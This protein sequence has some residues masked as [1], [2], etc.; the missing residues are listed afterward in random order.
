MIEVYIWTIIKITKDL[1]LNANADVL[2][3]VITVVL[4]ANTVQTANA[5]NAKS[6]TNLEDT[7]NGTFL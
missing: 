3:T 1:H 2:H 4:N 6:S 7:I 5:L